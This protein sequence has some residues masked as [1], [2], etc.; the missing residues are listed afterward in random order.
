MDLLLL[1][2]HIVTAI[3]LIDYRKNSTAWLSYISKIHIYAD[4]RTAL[5]TVCPL[6]YGQQFHYCGARI[7]N[8]SLHS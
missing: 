6:R 5:V 2:L 3:A 4:D 8:M 1:E 7:L